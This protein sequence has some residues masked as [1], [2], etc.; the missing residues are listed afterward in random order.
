MKKKSLYMRKWRAK[1]AERLREYK[2]V[3]ARNSRQTIKQVKMEQTLCA[4]CKSPT[5]VNSMICRKCY[6]QN[7]RKLYIPP[8]KDPTTGEVINRGLPS[9]KDYLEAD[10]LRSL[11][12]I[13]QKHK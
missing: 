7:G 11:K 8:E 4:Q 12:D 1:N 6:D 9:Y 13:V 10:R 2:R 3:W 5:S